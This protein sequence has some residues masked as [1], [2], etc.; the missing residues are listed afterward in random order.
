MH[1]G[2]NGYTQFTDLQMFVI[3]YSGW[4]GQGIGTKPGAHDAFIDVA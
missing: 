3:E 1:Y 4:E 2:H